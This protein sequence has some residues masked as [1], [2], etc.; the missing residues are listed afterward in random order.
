MNT[1]VALCTYNGERYIEQQIDSILNQTVKVDEIVICDDGSTDKTIQ[2]LEEYSK[3][4][5]HIRVFK[6]EVT[7]GSVRNFEKAILHCVGEYIFLSDQDDVWVGNKVESYLVYFKNNPNVNVIASNGYGIDEI[8]NKISLPSVWDIPEMLERNNLEYDYF[9]LITQYKNIATGASM[10]LKKSFVSEVVPFPV[11]TG[12]QHD[13]WMATIASYK[14]SFAYLKE[15][16]F[17]YR[18]HSSQQVGGVF[19]TKGDDKFFQVVQ[20]YKLVNKKF[21]LKVYKISLRNLAL[22]YSTNSKLYCYNGNE[23]F[24]E[25]MNSIKLKFLAVKRMMKRYYPLAYF[26]LTITDKILKKRQLT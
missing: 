5:P 2:I 19:F 11:I 8:N 3:I 9:T 22:C 21:M 1:S 12:Y 14:G 23:V 24:L 25:N 18:I 4:V 10:C 16:Y 20:L 26:T 13:E 6:N 17:Y 7:L 15:K